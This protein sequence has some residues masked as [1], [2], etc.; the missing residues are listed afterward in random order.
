MM[1][2][3]VAHDCGYPLS[4]YTCRASLHVSQLISWILKRFA[5]V[6]AVSR[7]TP[8]KFWCRTFPPPFPRGVAPKF[9]SG[10]VSR[11]TGVSQLQF[12]GVALHCAI[13]MQY[14]KTLSCLF[15]WGAGGERTMCAICR[16]I[17]YRTDVPVR[18]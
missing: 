3:L 10:K 12:A 16:K 8:K 7:H 18:S 15:V 14:G 2:Y 1:Q 5:G 4:R 17:G 6:A 9:G 11:Y 13:K